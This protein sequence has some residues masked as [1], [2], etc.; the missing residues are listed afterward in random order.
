ML[1]LN[2]VTSSRKQRYFS[3]AI[4]ILITLLFGQHHIEIECSDTELDSSTRSIEFF[5]FINIIIDV[6]KF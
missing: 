6:L 3:V 4:W 1:I 2:Q 5:C